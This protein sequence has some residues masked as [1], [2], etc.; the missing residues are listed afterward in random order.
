LTIEKV[1]PLHGRQGKV[2]SNAYVR[3]WD[4]LFNF[5]ALQLF[6]LKKEKREKRKKKKKI[7]GG[8]VH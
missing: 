2:A 8:G 4:D 6:F 5:G 1:P 3:R 7:R